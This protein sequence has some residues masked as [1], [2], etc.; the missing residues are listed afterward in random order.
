MYVG[1]PLTRR[2]CAEMRRKTYTSYAPYREIFAIQFGARRT[3]SPPTMLRNHVY[4]VSPPR[5]VRFRVKVEAS[6]ENATL[7]RLQAK[8]VEI[9]GY[10]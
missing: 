10:P 4:L 3:N 6:R 7:P 8:R 1:S 5:R 2:I 9:A